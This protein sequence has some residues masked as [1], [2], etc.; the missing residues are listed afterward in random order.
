MASVRHE[1]RY[2]FIGKDKKTGPQYL[3]A[4]E[5]SRKHYITIGVK[6]AG[7]GCIPSRGDIEERP[8]AGKEKARLGGL[9]SF[10]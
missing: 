7:R 2:R 10:I 6:N 9:E 8:Q 5:T 4:H 1:T 3:Y